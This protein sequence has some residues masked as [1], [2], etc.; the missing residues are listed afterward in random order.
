MLHKSENAIKANQR[1]ALIALRDILT[2]WE[3]RDVKDG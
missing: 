3:V 1:R 2:D